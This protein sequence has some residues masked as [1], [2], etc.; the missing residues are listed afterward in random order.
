[1]HYYQFN[2]ADYR[3]DTMHLS[4]IEHYI[5]R[6]LLDLIYLNEKPITQNNPVVLRLLRL[7]SEHEETLQNILDEFFILTEKGYIQDRAM[8]EIKEYQAYLA[9]QKSNGSK[10]G[11]PKKQEVTKD[12][13]PPGNPKKPSGLFSETQTKPKKTLTTNHKPLTN[14]KN[15]MS[16]KPDDAACK[17]VLNYLNST[18]GG[19]FRMVD[20]NL[21]L[22]RG[23]FREG[24]TREDFER[25]INQ[26]FSEWRDDPKMAKYL[27]PATL[28]NAEKFNS[29]AGEVVKTKNINSYMQE[30]LRGPAL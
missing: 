14:N 22:I 11:R 5:Y 18:V 20:S 3:K 30:V 29:Y 10:G 1:M 15:T 4:P 6:E 9:K 16:G 2:I 23:R 19:N 25:V 26:K 21:K 7:G 13:N 12:K 24:Y 17:E 8:H 27:R 28:F